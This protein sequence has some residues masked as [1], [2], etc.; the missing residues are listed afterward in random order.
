MIQEEIKN[1]EIEIPEGYEAKIENNKVI[2]VPKDSE[3]E[4][5]RKALLRC[6]DDWEK[7]QFGCMAKEDIPAIRAYLEKQKEQNPINESN[8]HEPTLDEARKWNEAYEKGYSLG[9][10]NGRNEQKP[11]EWSEEDYALLKEIVSFFKDG[12]VKLQHDLDLYAGFLENKFKSLL[13]QPK[14]EW[15]EEDEKNGMNIHFNAR[16]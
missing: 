12:T 16:K 14:Q 2:F 13:P 9:Y 5:I 8:M 15:S 4:K 11:A 3:D 10:E 6:C 1:K 7:G